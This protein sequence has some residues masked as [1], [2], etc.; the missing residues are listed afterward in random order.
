MGILEG[1]SEIKSKVIIC[2]PY[3]YFSQVETLSI[4]SQLNLG[5]QNIN[6]I[7]IIYYKKSAILRY[8]I[9]KINQ[10]SMLCLWLK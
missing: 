4:H 10:C 6:G 2:A 1:L 5:A 7:I 9:V 8:L 3:P